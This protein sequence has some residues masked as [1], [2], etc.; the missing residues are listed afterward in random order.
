MVSHVFNELASRGIGKGGPSAIMRPTATP[1]VF[2]ALARVGAILVPVNPD[3]AATQ[4]L[5]AKSVRGGRKRSAIRYTIRLLGIECSQSA[6]SA[7]SAA[8]KASGWS[9]IR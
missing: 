9:S 7:R 6:S 1:L 8:M 4:A 2:F 5:S 3:F